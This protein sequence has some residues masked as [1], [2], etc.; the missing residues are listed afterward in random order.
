MT[1]DEIGT[2]RRRFAR[3]PRPRARRLS[4]ILRQL[5][6]DRSRE[7]ISIRDLFETMGDRATGALMLVFALPNLVPTPPGTSA[8]LGTPLLFLA[9]QLAFGL[10]P[11]LP[12]VIAERSMRR[13][14]FE[15]IVSR[16]RRWLTFAE[17]MLK[18]RLS[19]LVEPPV[20][21]FAGF[22]CLVMAIILTLPIPLGN[23]LPAL[24]ICLFSFGILGR[25]GLFCL[26]GVVTSVVSGAV[27]GGMV[28]GIVKAAL[29]VVTNWFA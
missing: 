9:A 14:D 8:I 28:Y 1:I 27:V 5:A 4:A 2:T 24:A 10:K 20:E 29:F 16:L 15:A 3:N 26:L 23:M 17:R 21:Y 12:K 11:W 7:R 19:F 13:E 22:I 25:D 6:G 18:P